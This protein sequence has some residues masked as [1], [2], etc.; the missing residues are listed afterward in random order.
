MRRRRRLG[1]SNAVVVVVVLLL[2]LEIVVLVL[3]PL[4]EAG[5]ESIVQRSG[6]W[7]LACRS[8]RFMPSELSL[9]ADG[10][11]NGM[12]RAIAGVLERRVT[13]GETAEVTIACGVSFCWSRI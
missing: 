8:T 13:V 12:E 5:V 11:G 4:I 7:V 3:P 2:L 10:D 6:R 9:S 1:R